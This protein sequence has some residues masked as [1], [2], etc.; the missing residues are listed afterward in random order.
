MI[1]LPRERPSRRA[2][3]KRGLLAA[4]LA[5]LGHG[6]F[7]LILLFVSLLH[8]HL[9]PETRRLS[10]STVS[11]RGV[12]QDQWDANRGQPPALDQKENQKTAQREHKEPKKVEKKPPEQAP[13]QVVA[14]APGNNQEDP[15]AKFASETSNKVAKQTR[16]KEQTANY[17]NAMPKRTSNVPQDGNGTDT[18]DKAQVGGNNGIGQDACDRL[19]LREGAQKLQMEVPDIKKRSEVAMRESAPTGVGIDIANR[20]ETEEVQGNS[21]RLKLRM[22]SEGASEDTSEG[23]SGQPGVANLLPSAAVLDKIVGAA[24]NDHLKDIDEG[25]GT[26]LNTREWKYASFFNRVKQSVGQN[27]NPGAQLRLRDPTGNIYGGRDRYTVLNVTLTDQGRVREVFVE[28]SCGLDFLDL[29]AVQSFER[30]QPFPNPP[31]GL[32]QADASVKF[33]FGFFLE[34]SGS[35]RMRL[36]RAND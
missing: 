5:V 21:K 36:F 6:I 32:I 31:A 24:A 23:R 7:L 10:N 18:A 3:L 16:A 29:E 28:K 19:P 4:L 20:T 9:P 15:N 34:M 27:W 2:G 1:L 26:Y 30:A 17:R 11:L 13:G 35:P 12:S 33:Q 8:L 14:V 25:D 22:G